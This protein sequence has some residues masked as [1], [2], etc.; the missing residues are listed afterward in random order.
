[1]H[2]LRYSVMHLFFRATALYLLSAMLPCCSQAQDNYYIEDTHTFHGALIAG[3]NFTQVDGD[4][5]Y[6]YDKTGMNVGGGLY[7]M[8]SENMA[9][10]LELLYVQKG[11]KGKPFK[12]TEIDVTKYSIN[13]NYAEIPLQ[14]YYFD[15]HKNHFGAGFS[16]A[17]LI[18]SNEEIKAEPEQS[19]KPGEY[20]FRKFDVNF[21]MTGNFHLYKGFFIGGRF[22]YSVVPMR[23]NNTPP[24]FG[25][26]EQY[27]NVFNF[28]LMY[29]L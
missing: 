28:R 16:Y 22:Q 9:A 13:L 1:M 20:P 23:K 4:S 25:R 27:N 18:S 21:V 19:V 17:Q 12:T 24:N 5:Y 2:D 26:S 29:M 3:A 10:G 14:L 11:C 8:L 15:G 7:M 6:G